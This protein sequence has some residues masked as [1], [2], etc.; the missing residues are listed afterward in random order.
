MKASTFVAYVLSQHTPRL[1]FKL[2]SDLNYKRVPQLSFRFEEPDGDMSMF[3]KL[4]LMQQLRERHLGPESDTHNNQQHVDGTDAEAEH[5]EMDT[6]N[7]QID[8]DAMRE[9]AK[10]F[11]GG[12]TGGQPNEEMEELFAQL[13]EQQQKQEQEAAAN[14]DVTSSEPDLQCDE[15]QWTS[16]MSD[17]DASPV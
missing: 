8:L 9:L 2:G 12:S 14:D 1:R 15:E 13:Q 16:D 3:K 7:S 17:S 4:Q 5:N 6:S 11:S 10:M